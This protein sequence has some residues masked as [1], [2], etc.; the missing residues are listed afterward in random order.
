[1]QALVGALGGVQ[2]EEAGLPL[3]C[4]AAL[5]TAAPGKHFAAQFL[6]AGGAAPATMRRYILKHA[7]S[8]LMPP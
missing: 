8:W 2:D 6:E 5:V 3:T 1:M 7:R 4:V